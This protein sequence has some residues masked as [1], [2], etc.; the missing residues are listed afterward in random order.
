MTCT[1]SRN[2]SEKSQRKSAEKSQMAV[3]K[4]RYCDSRKYRDRGIFVQDKSI[5]ERYLIDHLRG[6]CL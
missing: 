4:N 3:A 1:K 5:G 6:Q 2:F